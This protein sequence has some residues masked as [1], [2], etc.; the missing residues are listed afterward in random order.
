MPV[1]TH[2]HFVHTGLYS[3]D[4]VHIAVSFSLGSM[5]TPLYVIRGE[6][7]MELDYWYRSYRLACQPTSIDIERRESLLGVYFQ[8]L[9]Y[10]LATAR[11]RWNRTDC[12]R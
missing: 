11:W 12:F 8:Y 7:D 10:D 5:F 3:K 4:K 2:F 1:S 6:P 9:R